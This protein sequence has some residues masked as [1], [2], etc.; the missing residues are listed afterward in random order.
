MTAPP[1]IDGRGM[2]LFAERARVPQWS[3][4]ANRAVGLVWL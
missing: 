4:R 3:L 2:D 1:G